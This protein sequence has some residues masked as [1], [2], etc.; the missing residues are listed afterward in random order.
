M[1]N[2]GGELTMRNFID[3]QRKLALERIETMRNDEV[4]SKS[5]QDWVDDLV[6]VYGTPEIPEINP[7]D[8]TRTQQQGEVPARPVPNPSFGENVPKVQGLIHYIHIP[9]TGN[10]NFFSY[11]RADGGEF[12]GEV[13]AREIVLAIGGAWLTP[14]GIED[15]VDSQVALIDKSLA[16]FRSD[17]ERFREYLPGALRPA[18]ELR[19]Q[20]AEAEAQTAAGLRY[21]IKPNPNAPPPPTVPPIRKKI[22]PA[23]LS[24]ASTSDPTPLHEEHYQ[25][26]LRICENMA[27]V[28]ERSPSAFEKMK[29]EDLRW[30][31]IVQ[32]NAQ[33]DGV[34]GEA[35]NYQ[36]K[37]DILV[38][39]GNHN[40]F[41][42]ECKK[43]SGAKGLTDTLEQLFRYVTWRDTKTAI[44]KFVDHK[45]FT[46]IVEEATRTMD[47]HPL[48]VGQPKR[49]GDARFRYH[50]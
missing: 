6:Q 32:L 27:T 12:P 33:Y 30:H 34:S 38:K 24:R 36:G 28:M 4:L 23:P 40:I 20:T 37:T 13:G 44:I 26:I 7:A 25:N 42:A 11:E 9:F 22:A 50:P 14:Q 49:E 45:D 17:A 47:S 16:S 5:V 1:V 31:F 18:L 29:E 3:V 35:F 2:P 10:R 39:M 8:I 19:R 46:A 15:M 41:I 48:L 43:W 21:P